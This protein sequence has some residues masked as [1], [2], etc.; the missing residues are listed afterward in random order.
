MIISETSLT[1]NQLV[2][3]G[4][5]SKT[6]WVGV[7]DDFITPPEQPQD[8]SLYEVALEPQRIRTYLITYVVFNT[9]TT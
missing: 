9:Q 8:K 2:Q 6:Q 7:D 4:E 5:S 3:Q 1:G